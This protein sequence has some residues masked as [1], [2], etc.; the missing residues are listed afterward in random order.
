MIN[1]E[2]NLR[3][4][5]TIRRYYGKN[6]IANARMHIR[7]IVDDIHIVYR[8]WNYHTRNWSYHI[9]DIYLFFLMNEH[10]HLY[11]PGQKVVE[12]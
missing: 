6:S 9:D 5:K 3:P 7:D 11:L 10:G 4:G 1:L 8:V 12:R 2:E